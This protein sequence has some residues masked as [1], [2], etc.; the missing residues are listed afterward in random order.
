LA[1]PRIEYFFSA[2]DDSSPRPQ[3]LGDGRV[4][5]HEL[6]LIENVVVGQ[7]LARIPPGEEGGGPDAFPVGE[8]VYVPEENPRVLVA[9]VNGHVF[10]KDGKIHVSPVYVVEGDV[11]FSTGNVVFV[12][13]LVVKGSIRAGFK[14]RAQ[15]LLVEGDV[16]GADIKVGEGMEVKGGVIGGEKGRV[17]CG[18]LKAM[19][20]LG[21]KVEAKGD[22]VLEKSSRNSV[23]LAEGEIRVE[24]DPGAIIGGEVRAAKGIKARWVG[25]RWGIPTEVVVGMNPFWE[26]ELRFLRGR[27]EELT[28]EFRELKARLRYLQDQGGNF[29]REELTRRLKEIKGKFEEVSQ[30]EQILEAKLRE[31]EGKVWVREGIYHGVSL[32]IGDVSHTLR[33]DIKGKWV[34]YSDGKQIKYRAW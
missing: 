11:D 20:A 26:D 2:R 28:R 6:G 33:E 14:V 7:V 32:R 21:A 1:K 34:F 13:R 31:G 25:A 23:I 16:E 18:G 22:V 10:W 8:N 12:G 17:E 27:K 5:F 29:E 19:Y 15:E 4:D 9:A 3:S 24:G 30:R